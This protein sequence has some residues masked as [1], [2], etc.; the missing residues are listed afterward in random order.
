MFIENKGGVQ[1]IS[2]LIA[3][4]TAICGDAFF[5]HMTHCAKTCLGSQT[6]L[7]VEQRY[8]PCIDLCPFPIHV[9][10]VSPGFR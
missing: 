8:S 4:M 3:C 5:T 9:Y 7:H 2:T 10:L 1:T 6:V